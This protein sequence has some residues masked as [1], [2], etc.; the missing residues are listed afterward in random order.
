MDAPAPATTPTIDSPSA[1]TCIDVDACERR[2][3]AI[4][5]GSSAQYGIDAEA[6]PLAAA[7]RR[8]GEPAWTRAAALALEDD[9]AVRTLAAFVLGEWEPL[10]E[11]KIPDLMAALDKDPGGWPARALGRLGTPLAVEMLIADIRRAGLG[12]QSTQGLAQTMPASLPVILERLRDDDSRWLAV[13]VGAQLDAMAHVESRRARLDDVSR[14]LVATA[15]DAN[16]N[17]RTRIEATRLL[18][19]IAPHPVLDLF[20]LEANRDH[21]DPVMRE[22]TRRLLMKQ[23]SALVIDAVLEECHELLGTPGHPGRGDSLQLVLGFGG[24]LEPLAR[25]GPAGRRAA[26][27]LVERVAVVDADARNLLLA[28]LGYLGDHDAVP[29]LVSALRSDDERDVTASL[30]SLWR[31]RATEALLD[32]R[33]VARSHWYAPVR[34]FAARVG[35]ALGGGATAPV[36]A[37]LASPDRRGSLVDR[38][39][40]GLHARK[41]RPVPTCVVWQV[42]GE[43]LRQRDDFES[44]PEVEAW[45]DDIKGAAHV[46]PFAG[47]VLLGIDKGEFGGG[48]VLRMRDGA[49]LELADENVQALLPLADGDVI[50]VVGHDVPVDHGGAV[51][52]L[53]AHPA[54]AHIVER[55]RLPSAPLLAQPAS[56]GWLV[57]MASHE[58]LLLRRDLSFAQATC[59]SAEREAGNR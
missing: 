3:R 5:Q 14:W 29:V 12:N 51:L 54:P 31:L 36:E 16:A 19:D 34:G 38:H 58:A 25:M 2:L 39:V 45:A 6:T 15:A 57:P 35:T 59:V 43:Q 40:W 33:V 44:T 8:L 11:G 47:G 30:E 18:L 49:Q 24:C 23:G 1:G 46:L 42:G 7:F 55:H 20:P 28:T 27:W 17:L 4:T 37:T 10:D 52:R 41:A 9:E 32:V 22:M 21:R 48:L 53:S 26:P 13:A 56:G 50:A